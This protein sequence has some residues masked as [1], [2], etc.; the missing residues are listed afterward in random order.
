M[1][2]SRSTDD[3]DAD[4]MAALIQR[5]QFDVA[6]QIC[7]SMLSRLDLQSDEAAKWVI[8]ASELSIAIFQSGGEFTQDQVVAAQRPVLGLLTRYADHRRRFFLLSQAQR[9]RIAAVR[10]AIVMASVAVDRQQRQ[11]EILRQSSSI[12][13]DV[14]ELLQQIRTSASETLS[15]QPTLQQ[16]AIVDDWQRLDHE[17]QIELV[18]LALMQ[19]E[20]FQPGSLDFIDAAN[21]AAATATETLSRL[22]NDTLARR[23]VQRLKADALIRA[24]QLREAKRLLDEIAGDTDSTLSPQMVAL[25]VRLALANGDVS[26]ARTQL[27]RF[28]GSDPESA[29]RSIELDLVR[30]EVLLRSVGGE[31]VDRI[32]P[33]LNSIEQRGGAFAR[34]RAESTAV[35]FSGRGAPDRTMQ[36]NAS[37]LAAQGEDWLR[38]GDELRA[39]KLLAAAADAE[40]D[41]PS[42]LRMATKSAAAYL[43]AKQSEDA[44]DVLQSIAKSKSQSEGADQLMLQAAVLLSQQSAKDTPKKI[45]QTLRDLITMWPE[46]QSSDAAKQWLLKL[47]DGQSR[48]A[49]A[50]LAATEFLNA[51]SKAGVVQS[52]MDRWVKLLVSSDAAQASSL[53]PQFASAWSTAAEQSSVAKE[54][55][56]SYSPLLLD[57]GPFVKPAVGGLLSDAD[58]K[59]IGEVAAFRDHQQEMVTPADA[60][61]QLIE[62]ARWRLLRDGELDSS[63][64]KRVASLLVAWPSRDRWQTWTALLWSGDEA[65]VVRE[66]EQW[67][68]ESSQPGGD[69]RRAAKLLSEQAS[70]ASKG[71]AIKIWDQ[72]ASGVPRG[73]VE[74][75]VAKLS[76]IALLQATGKSAEAVRRAKYVLLT[77][78]P[79]NSKLL[80]QYQSIR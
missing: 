2:V 3:R 39:A 18:A 34:R 49:E 53:I 28:Y 69:G 76:A 33:W 36:G 43:A 68:A 42:A 75:H 1:T 62:L 66:I 60:S 73:S 4:L 15:G 64:R 40:S 58:A 22:P 32:G 16:R 52:A 44:I 67:L 65:T 45:E 54:L 5:G 31:E 56:Q 6:N 48:E 57:E 14:E 35:S 13:L 29:P 19:S 10:H 70:V 17:L 59:L 30:L 41:G 63:E 74:W 26:G 8:H 61:E 9:V 12:R 80:E 7:R 24:G 77:S 38:R 51:N 71:A 46:S 20:I 21:Q 25:Q 50:A 79:K 47:L 23:E 72:I 78:P 55:F 37:V 27:D 11:S